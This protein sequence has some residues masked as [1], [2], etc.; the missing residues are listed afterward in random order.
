MR[1]YTTTFFLLIFLI[2]S[3][4]PNQPRYGK[5]DGDNST[6]YIDWIGYYE[7]ILPCA[8]CDGVKTSITLKEDSTYIKKVVYLGKEGEGFEKKGEFE[9]FD[10][11]NKIILDSR[12]GTPDMYLLGKDKLIHLDND[13][14]RIEGE[15][16]DDYI[17]NKVQMEAKFELTEPKWK[18][19]ELKGQ[20]VNNISGKEIF[21]AF[22]PD[23]A[24]VYGFAGCNNFFGQYKWEGQ[25]R[26]SFS[27]LG[28]TQKMCTEGMEI[29]EQLMKV[30]EMTDNFTITDDILNLNKA[31]M[32]TLAKF[33]KM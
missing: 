12:G 15:L 9:W 4:K 6:L 25:T 16:E 30:F 17:L 26:I 18:L 14:S 28:K 21:M 24:R 20:K 1:Y 33:E 7:G 13:G 32:A 23:K 2:F 22:E 27:N 31:R 19:I 5:Y 11:E 8:D 10:D 29:E 3:C